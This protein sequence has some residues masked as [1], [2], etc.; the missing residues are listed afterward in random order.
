MSHH[1]ANV[2]RASEE[3]ERVKDVIHDLYLR[4]NCL[5]EGPD[6]LIERM[7]KEHGFVKSKAQY[8]KQLSKW[9]FTKRTYHKGI[10]KRNWQDINLKVEQTRKRHRSLAKNERKEVTAY[11]L[12]EPITDKVLRT[13]GYLPSSEAASR[14]AASPQTPLGFDL[15]V[16]TP[17][18][19]EGYNLP[20]I[21]LWKVL[22]IHAAQ[23][24]LFPETTKHL[25]IG[26]KYAPQEVDLEDGMKRLIYVLSNHHLQD[27]MREVDKQFFLDVLTDIDLTRFFTF[28]SVASHPS[29]KALLESIFQLAMEVEDVEIVKWLLEN[30]IDPNIKR[31]WDS[32]K[33]VTPM[34]YA[35]DH[36]MFDMA[37]L[38]IRKRARINVDRGSYMYGNCTGAIALAISG[39]SRKC[40][41]GD[42][43]FRIGFLGVGW[44]Q[45]LSGDIESLCQFFKELVAAGAKVSMQELD[46]TPPDD[47]IHLGPEDS[48]SPLTIASKKGFFRT[49]T[50]TSHMAVTGAIH[51]AIVMKDHPRARDLIRKGYGVNDIVDDI[52]PETALSAAIRSGDR[53]LVD[54]LVDNGAKFEIEAGQCCCGHSS[55]INV[56]N[57]AVKYGDEELIRDLVSKGAKLTCYGLSYSAFSNES[58]KRLT[59]TAPASLQ[60]HYQHICDCGCVSPLTEYLYYGDDIQRVQMLLRLGATPDHP[61]PQAPQGPCHVSPLVALLMSNQCDK[62]FRPLATELL[63]SAGAN[64][65]DAHALMTMGS[66][67]LLPNEREAAEI[68]LRRILSLPAPSTLTPEVTLAETAALI[69][70]VQIMNID[71]VKAILE[72]RA[73][74][75]EVCPSPIT[76]ALETGESACVEIVSTLIQAGYIP[77][78]RGGRQGT[79]FETLEHRKDK[80]EVLRI[81]IDG[82]LQIR[83]QDCEGLDDPPFM[84]AAREPSSR[85]LRC[86]FDFKLQPTDDQMRMYYRAEKK[87]LGQRM[88]EVIF[89]NTVLQVAAFRGHVKVVHLLLEHGVDVNAAGSPDN[90]ATALQFALIDEHF[91]VAELLIKH[92]ADVN[93]PPASVNGSTCLQIVAQQGNL[94]WVKKLVRQGAA[95]NAMPLRGYKFIGTALQYAAQNGCLKMVRYL[96]EHDA[97]VNQEPASRAGATA[98]QYAAMHGFIAIAQYLL[99]HGANILASP[100][101]TEG[102]TA[103]EGASEH[104]R[105][106][107]V[108][109]LLHHIHELPHGIEPRQVI[110]KARDLAENNGHYAIR[111]MLVEH[112]DNPEPAE[113]RSHFEDVDMTEGIDYD[114]GGLRDIV[115][116]PDGFFDLD[117]YFASLHV[118]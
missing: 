71:F 29:F 101:K 64:P 110:G 85:L 51:K 73:A 58:L 26:A 27:H 105:V 10:S 36:G 15:V 103:L 21:D 49:D 40:S 117:D 82:G 39:W 45:E 111:D 90:G 25:T 118:G 32:E 75:K 56:L 109:L 80:D 107:M 34:E 102:R 91:D 9:G 99:R 12:D 92:G 41:W 24:S 7:E 108:S 74:S 1:L 46:I 83:P 28:P 55:Q 60:D 43:W 104:G 69:G 115:E 23:H 76:V 70:A 6:G 100:A 20:F 87:A 61:S 48:H 88:P 17:S 62:R 14:G 78:F 112:F 37:R 42:R 2:G 106:D 94:G 38:L 65:F 53:D 33:P 57:V 30:G 5:L 63:L 13:Q 116:V 84:V 81:L 18:P 16:R 114:F 66:D 47:I 98:L 11:L 8:A 52:V 54:E 4:D 79:I 19:S 35:L 68:L 3:W 22:R 97:D 67:G 72:R 31:L 77:H 93:A 113:E 89:T 95:V 44:P 86:L 59:I 96:V 50:A